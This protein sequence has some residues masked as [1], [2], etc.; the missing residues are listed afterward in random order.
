[1]IDCMF[2]LDRKPVPMFWPNDLT[3]NRAWCLLI[4]L[5]YVEKGIQNFEM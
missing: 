2:L 1:M 4:E 3:L 5:V